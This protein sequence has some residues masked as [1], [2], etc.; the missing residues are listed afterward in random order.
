MLKSRVYGQT[1][2]ERMENFVREMR[3]SE[4]K[5][6]STNFYQGMS[7]HACVKSRIKR[8]G[9]AIWT[10]KMSR[11][12]VHESRIL[13]QPHL[14]AVRTQQRIGPYYLTCLDMKWS[15]RTP[16]VVNSSLNDF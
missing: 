10:P 8:L 9:R 2:C 12:E 15:V 7:G 13:G 3:E 11:L 1:L 5:L 14:Q 6:L 4:L 16:N